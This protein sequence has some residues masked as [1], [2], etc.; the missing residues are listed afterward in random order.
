MADISLDGKRVLI[1]EDLNVPLLNRQGLKRCRIRAAL[2]TIRAALTA[3]AAVMLM[4]HLGRPTEGQ[5]AG[6]FSL[7]P[8]A[9][10]LGKLLDRNVPLIADWIDGVDVEPGNVV[11]LEKRA[12]PRG[13]ESLRHRAGQKDGSAVRHIRHGRIWYGSP[14]PRE[15]LR[16]SPNTRPS[17]ARDRYWPPELEA[18][19]RALKEPARPLVAVVGGSK[20]ST[21]AVC[22][23]Y[24]CRHC[25]CADCGWRYR[26]HVHCC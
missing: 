9:D 19:G 24:A 4:S 22:S 12:L 10:H 1:R 16:L 15:Y 2:P 3:N 20:V 14:R 6:E 17:H 8:V 7:K 13:R 18:L 23:G 25:R 11:L 26:E 5:P 21:Q